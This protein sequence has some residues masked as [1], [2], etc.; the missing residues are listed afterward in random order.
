MRCWHD[1]T[2]L[3]NG[4]VALRQELRVLSR[5]DR[6]VRAGAPRHGPSVNIV[7][8][9]DRPAYRRPCELKHASA[10]DTAYV[11]R[12]YSRT[13]NNA[14]S[15]LRAPV[16]CV[17]FSRHA[18]DCHA[19]CFRCAEATS[20]YPRWH[21]RVLRCLR[22]PTNHTQTS[23]PRDLFASRTAHV[24]S[25]CECPGTMGLPSE[26]SHAVPPENT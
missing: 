21:R 19:L 8:A 11:L 24:G 23:R 7:L 12:S 2:R 1:F 14:L 16:L 26:S 20:R 5:N 10:S 18:S 17:A 3:Q 15:L 22:L 6:C 4:C 9:C 13:P 25:R